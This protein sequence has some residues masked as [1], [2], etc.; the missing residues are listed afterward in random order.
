MAELFNGH[1]SNVAQVDESLKPEDFADH[2]SI[3]L[4]TENE[5]M[6]NFNFEPVNSSYARE[7]INNLNPMK[8]VR[9][10]GISPRLL[11]LSAP[12]L[13][14]EV[15]KLI[16]YFIANHTWP[17]EW[18]SS[19]ITPVFKKQED[20]YKGNYRPVL[21]LTTLSN[22]YEKILFDQMYRALNNH[23]SLNLSGFL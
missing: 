8:A 11:R 15:T 20:K 4:I 6:D 13:A 16:N 10:D 23:L 1:F 19:N 2:S 5:F 17:S 14:E 12:V 18:K 7:I 22:I 9:V 21:I 3:K